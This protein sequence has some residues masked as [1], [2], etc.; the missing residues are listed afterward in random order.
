LGV[1]GTGI[2]DAPP[3]K[4]FVGMPRLTVVMV[5]HI[6][7]FPDVL[8][9]EGKKTSAYRQVGNAYPAPVYS[10]TNTVFFFLGVV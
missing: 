3:R 6:K 9:F 1:D 2:A 4:R 10:Q 8:Q 7:G 5:A